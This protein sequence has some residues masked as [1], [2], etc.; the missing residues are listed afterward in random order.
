MEMIRAYLKNFARIAAP[1]WGIV[2]VSLI[3]LY[4]ISRLSTYALEAIT[5]GLTIWQM[6]VLVLNV[7]F[8]AY[9][10]G[11]RGFHLRFSPR[12]VAR[13][14]YLHRS[15]TLGYSLLAPLFCAG[16]FAA[17]RRTLMTIWI[18]TLA[19]VGAVMLVHNLGQPWRGILDAGVVV[20][21][22]WGQVS[23]WIIAVQ[24]F[25]EG[26]YRCSPEIP[27]LAVDPSELC[28]APAKHS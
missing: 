9:S 19:I 21:L 20:G 23:L 11:Y 24:V 5:G 15:P 10:E 1:L 7:I 16:Y 4:A 3:L 17:T 12:V 22:T 13:A 28:S 27:G 2:G 6:T 25:Q 14:L 18:G 8:M 26:R